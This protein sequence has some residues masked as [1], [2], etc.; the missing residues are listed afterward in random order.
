MADR[1]EKGTRMLIWILS[2]IVLFQLSSLFF[3]KDPLARL[4]VP[5]A[6][7]WEA[8]PSTNSNAGGKDLGTI[9]PAKPASG[10]TNSMA[11]NGALSMAKAGTTNPV[12]EAKPQAQS[13]NSPKIAGTTN[14]IPALTATNP[15]SPARPLIAGPGM[16]PGMMPGMGGPGRGGGKPLSASL[17]A[18]V[19]KITQSEILA[20]I[21]RPPP[22]ALLGIA[23]RDAFLRT[24]SGQTQILREGAELDGV[25]LLRIG[26]NRVLVEHAGEKKE[27][28]IF[29]GF[30][31]ES[32]LPK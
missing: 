3:R 4:Q 13:T 24:P 17:Q 30:G 10:G 1:F 29:A 26:T 14:A 16:I 22:M 20:P 18:R 7:R 28:M 9:P 6:P 32:L 11:T 15:P 12:P 21:M 23:G 25:R 2:G 8:A 19:D 27:L 5:T 31:G